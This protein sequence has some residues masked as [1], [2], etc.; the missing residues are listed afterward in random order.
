MDAKYIFNCIV[1]RDYWGAI[2]NIYGDIESIVQ[3]VEGRTD[4]SHVMRKGSV[5]NLLTFL[6]SVSMHDAIFWEVVREI[7]VYI[8]RKIAKLNIENF[9]IIQVDGEGKI[10]LMLLYMIFY[11]YDARS[12]GKLY[13]GAD[14]EF[15]ERKIAL[16]QVGFYP[17]RKNKFIW[18]FDPNSLN[19]KQT[20]YLVKFYFTSSYLN[21]IVHGSDSLDIPYLFQ[22]MFMNNEAYIYAFVSRVIDTRFLC[23]YY[24][25]TVGGD[26]KCSLYDAMLYFD[27]V[28]KG[29]YDELQ[30]I[31]KTMGP[32]QDVNWNVYNMSSF[33][34][35]YAIYDVFYLRDFYFDILGK[36]EKEGEGY[37]TYEYVLLFTRFIFLEKWGVSDLLAGIKG[38]VDGVNNYIVMKGDDVSSIKLNITMVSVYGGVVKEMGVGALLD[39]NYFRSSLTLL[40]KMIMYSI[41]TE[42]YT[43]YKNKEDMY[44]EKIKLDEVFD[45]FKLIH[46]EG[47]RRF[48]K[49]FYRKA[50]AK[51]AIYMAGV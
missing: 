38:K 19:T 5:Y 1:E 28:S 24:K 48:C 43:I 4:Y 12:I 36:G 29:K 51:I 40:F 26:R 23:E 16:C 50:K 14:F 42:Y 45:T 10:K 46:L 25:N 21:K 8:G 35:K 49:R 9:N 15:N 7:V 31:N 41:L 22:E 30:H 44:V 20:D 18:V 33:N 2:D 37:G 11:H 27:T 13:T 6:E 39:I 32:I 3:R 47:L 17:H 34:L